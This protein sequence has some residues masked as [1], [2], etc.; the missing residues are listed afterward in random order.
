MPPK[1]KALTERRQPA[2]SSITVLNNE[3]IVDFREADFLCVRFSSK[4]QCLGLFVRHG[5]SIGPNT[6]F[7]PYDGITGTHNVEAYTLGSTCAMVSGLVVCYAAFANDNSPEGN[8]ATFVK[9]DGTD[10]YVLTTTRAVNSN[11]E[12]CVAYGMTYWGEAAT[13]HGKQ[14]HYKIARSALRAAQGDHATETK[15]GCPTCSMQLPLRVLYLHLQTCRP[16]TMTPHARIGSLL[17][18]LPFCY[19]PAKGKYVLLAQKV[20]E[21]EVA[22]ATIVVAIDDAFATANSFVVGDSPFARVHA[23]LYARNISIA[24]VH[25]DTTAFCLRH[26][27]TNGAVAL[28]LLDLCSAFQRPWIPQELDVLDLA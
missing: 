28:G 18:L 20:D 16:R 7:A 12:I 14:G 27:E 2:R 22:D 15:V 9:K 1:K 3:N 13:V 10:N 21:A 11:E 4:F 26:L 24:D 19:Y 23:E 6:T 8:C 5:F 25:K 17:N